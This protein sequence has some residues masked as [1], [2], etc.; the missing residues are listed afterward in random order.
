MSVLRMLVDAKGAG[1]GCCIQ[2]TTVRPTLRPQQGWV[3]KGQGKS[4]KGAGETEQGQEMLNG[5]LGAVGLPNPG[6]F[7]TKGGGTDPRVKL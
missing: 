2:E 7:Q 3:A 6:C 5:T 4:W 1:G